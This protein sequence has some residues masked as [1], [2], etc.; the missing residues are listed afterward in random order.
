LLTGGNRA[1]PKGNPVFRIPQ[2]G[3]AELITHHKVAAASSQPWR[4]G[5]IEAVRG[6][7]IAMRYL[8]LAAALC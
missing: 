5:R 8:E 7:G 3:I 1:E 2:K 6:S 4:R